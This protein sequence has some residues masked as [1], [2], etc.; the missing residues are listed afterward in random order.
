MSLGTPR[1]I[2]SPG[3]RQIEPPVDQRLTK[4]AGI[5]QKHP[6][7][8]VLDPSSRA[9]ILP[10]HPNR[11]AALFQEARFIDNEHVS[12][13]TQR[14]DDIAAN[15]IAQHIFIP[16]AAAQKRLHPIRTFKPCLFG[17]QPAGLARNARQQPR[18]L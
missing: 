5:G 1:V 15:F 2:L 4:A 18:S 12:R 8:A 11:M 10:R 3:L 9:G 6:H 14:F 16:P 13:I 7:L 17:H